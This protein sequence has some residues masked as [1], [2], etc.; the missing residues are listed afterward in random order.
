MSGTMITG[1]QQNGAAE[2]ELIFTG[3]A[4]SSDNQQKSSQQGTNGK[5]GTPESEQ[6]HNT[7]NKKWSVMIV[8]QP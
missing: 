8:K 4:G 3:M 2:G 5:T 7:S 6:G 1:P